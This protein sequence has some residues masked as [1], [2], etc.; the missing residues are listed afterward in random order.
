MESTN[1]HLLYD[2]CHL[3]KIYQT[4]LT[5]R[6]ITHQFSK[7]V[8]ALTKECRQTQI[9]CM[10][11]LGLVIEFTEFSTPKVPEGCSVILSMSSCVAVQIRSKLIEP[12][13]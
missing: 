4:T 7:V 9:K 8:D 1:E 13:K 2:I 3:F 6:Y 11:S 5:E 10:F 12:G